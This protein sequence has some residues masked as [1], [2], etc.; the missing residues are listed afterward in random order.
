MSKLLVILNIS[1]FLLFSCDMASSKYENKCETYYVTASKLNVRSGAGTNY[2]EIGKLNYG[3]QVCLIEKFN[4][5][6]YL[7][8]TS[9]IKQG[10]FLKGYVSSRYLSSLK[11]TT[12][13]SKREKIKQKN[14]VQSGGK[15]CSFKNYKLGADKRN[16]MSNNPDVY[17][18]KYGLPYYTG[19][20]ISSKNMKIYEK[21]NVTF[22]SKHYGNISFGFYNGKLAI[23]VIEHKDY[24]FHENFLNIL[25]N[26]YGKYTDYKIKSYYD[27]LANMTKTTEN[28]YWSKSNCTLCYN[29]TSVIDL[30][31]LIFYDNIVQRKIK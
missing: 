27:P 26:K 28:Y 2:E 11:T 31:I 15:L 29:Y 5:K 14:K 13:T 7:V 21:E 1:L 10:F 23:I 24:Q 9:E 3:Q 6:W 19:S 4:S 17:L 12:T 30:A 20:N 25:I 16:F 18:S 22:F 8:E